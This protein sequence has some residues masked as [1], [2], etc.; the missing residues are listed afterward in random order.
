LIGWLSASA[1]VFV[2]PNL[3]LLSPNVANALIKG[4]T[5]PPKTKSSIE[6]LKCTNIDECQALG[7]Q[8]QH[9]VEQAQ[10]ELALLSPPLLTR[11]GVK[12][13][14]VQPGTGT[15][16]VQP[17]DQVSLAYKV[18]KLGKRSYDG[19]SGE[20][21]VI[22]SRGYGLEDDEQRPGDT[23]WST[24]VAD[25]GQIHNNNIVALE[26]ALIGMKVHGI[27]RFSIVPQFGWERPTR[28]CDGGPGGRGPGGDV[29]VDYVVVPSATM[30]ATEACLDTTRQPFPTTYAQ[31]RRM[32]QRFDQTLL[33]EVQVLDINGAKP[34]IMGE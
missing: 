14:D 28:A 25:D 26:E 1:V 5:P 34:N 18:L 31:Q 8:Q 30:V 12:Y 15:T 29:K 2:I 9:D 7:E 16:L 13:R 19:L 32:A 23:Y 11:K 22:F 17:G 20:G 21:T 6:K 10:R 24:T 3:L 33:M 27:R 4:N